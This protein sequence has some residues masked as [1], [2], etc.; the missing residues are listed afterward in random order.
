M[1]LNAGT[2]SD[3]TCKKDVVDPRRF[4][5]QRCEILDS[6]KQIK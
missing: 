1:K 4:Y 2:I 5:V 3:H 6:F